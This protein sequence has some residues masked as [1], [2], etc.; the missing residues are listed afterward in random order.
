[1]KRAILLLLLASTAEAHFVPADRMIVVQAEPDGVAVLVTYRPPSGER[2]VLTGLSARHRPDVLRALLSVQAVAGVALSADGAPLAAG[3]VETKLVEDPPG[4]GRATVVV[5]L[6]ARRPPRARSVNVSVVDFGE[7]TRTK[8][9]DRS[10]GRIAQF[11]PVAADQWIGGRSA[12]SLVWQ[13]KEG[14]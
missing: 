8:W 1:M 7:P 14:P 13:E 9:V 11:G 4:S 10:R 2:S 5:L 3:S 6:T 12:I